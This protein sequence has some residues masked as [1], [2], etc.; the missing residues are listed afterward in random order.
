MQD[1]AGVAP[2]TSLQRKICDPAAEGQHA[3]TTAGPTS[4][5]APRAPATKFA[6]SSRL[7]PRPRRRQSAVDLPGSLPVSPPA[8]WI[9]HNSLSNPV[10][11]GSC[12]AAVSFGGGPVLPE[13]RLFGSGVAECYDGLFLKWRN[14]FR[15]YRLERLPPPGRAGARPCRPSTPLLFRTLALMAGPS[16]EGQT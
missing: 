5:G 11:A 8:P 1:A 9:R 7:L 4:L 16:A 15:Q 2:V 13:C 10:L 3:L 6:E 14:G 12:G